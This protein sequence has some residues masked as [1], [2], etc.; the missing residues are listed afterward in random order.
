MT[1]S[2]THVQHITRTG[3]VDGSLCA[4]G[5][6]GNLCTDCQSGWGRTQLFQCAECYGAATNRAILALACLL[7]ILFLWVLIWRTLKEAKHFYEDKRVK[8]VLSICIKIGI[9]MVQ[10]NALAVSFDYQVIIVL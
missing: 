5:Y 9:S 10:F 7:I 2:N 8:R 1:D 3:G 6:Q 4:V